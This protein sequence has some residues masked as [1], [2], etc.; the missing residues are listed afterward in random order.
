[1]SQLWLV[2]SFISA[3]V[4]VSYLASRD[5]KKKIIFFGDSITQEGIEPNGYITLLSKMLQQQ[6]IHNY[7]LMCAGIGGNKVNDLLLRMDDDV[8]RKF[9]NMVVIFI[10]VNDVWH[11]KTKGAGTEADKF[12]EVY[13]IIVSKL[14]QSGTKVI[15]CTPAVIGEKYD[16]TNELDEDLN[17]YCNIVRNMAA[18]LHLP[19][20]DIRKAFID[21]ETK[22]NETNEASGILTTDGVHLN[23]KGNELV[24]ELMWSV[25]K[26]VK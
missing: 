8:L 20:V 22:N 26:N 16:D 1:M 2:I 13:N 24:A 11:K 18:Y 21:Y 7:Q 3:L 15:L 17:R 25:I 14:I 23:D 5:K 10:G 19:L 4:L 6:N 9:P 12:E